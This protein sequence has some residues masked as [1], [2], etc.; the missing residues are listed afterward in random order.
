M[1]KSHRNAIN[2]LLNK[3]NYI[4][5]DTNGINKIS[6]WKSGYNKCSVR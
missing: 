2:N 3:N 1:H 6:G 5:Y 4:D